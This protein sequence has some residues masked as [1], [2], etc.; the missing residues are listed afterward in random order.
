MILSRSVNSSSF[1]TIHFY[2]L[3][4][5]MCMLFEHMLHGDLHEFLTTH[6]PNIDSSDVSGG[7]E[8]G[9]DASVLNPTDMSFIAIQVAAGME[10]L[11][12]HHYVHRYWKCQFRLLWEQF[13]QD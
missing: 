2:F 11:A 1:A 9:G 8:D 4:D 5:P 13:W 7:G 12:S 10:Y 3:D 6:S